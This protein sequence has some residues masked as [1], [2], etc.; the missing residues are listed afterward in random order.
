M[1]EINAKL[2]MLCGTIKKIEDIDVTVKALKESVN[3]LVQENVSLRAELGTRDVKIQQLTD[4]VNRLDQAS[5]SSSLRILGLPVSTSSTPAQI[6]DAVYNEIL[7]P[8]LEAAKQCGDISTHADLPTH[9]LIVNAFAIPSKKNSTTSTVIVKLHSEF[10]R[11]LVFK[12]KKASLPTLLDSTSNR[13]RNKFSI[14]EDLA[15]ATHALLRSLLEDIR[16][17]SVWSYGGQVRFKSHES[18]V[19]YRAKSLTDTFDSIL[20]AA[21]VKPT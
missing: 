8:V 5:L 15:P 20:K 21:G 2:D 9:F 6:F 10:I 18:E 16:V 13:V 17:K 3:H 14:F 11:S 7:I 12:H 1:E 4:Q 19:V